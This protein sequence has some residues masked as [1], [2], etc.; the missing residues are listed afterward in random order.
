MDS[1]TI[2]PSHNTPDKKDMF[3]MSLLEYICIKHDPQKTSLFPELVGYLQSN[4]MIKPIDYNSQQYTAIKNS[5]L[6]MLHKFIKN[7][8]IPDSSLPIYESRYVNDF[9]EVNKI[10]DGGF[11]SVYKTIHKLDKVAY[12][13]KKIPLDIVENNKEILNES[14]ILAHLNHNNIIRYYSTW[15]EQI[16]TNLTL[17]SNFDNNCSI[18]YDD[19][20]SIYYDNSPSSNNELMLYPNDNSS[21]SYDNSF[22]SNDNKIIGH[23]NPLS[24][25]LFIQMELCVM[26]L[27]DYIFQPFNEVERHYMTESIIN[28]II[29][30]HSQEYI[31]CDLSLNNILLNKDKQIKLCDFGLTSYVGNNGYIIKNKHYGNPLY[32]AP[33]SLSFNKYSYKSDIYSLGIIFFELQSKFTTEME[34]IS[35]IKAFRNKKVKCKYDAYLYSLT[36]NDENK[37][38]FIYD[39]KK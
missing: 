17:T 39:L 11:G 29:Y 32:L 19:S 6:N 22:N 38:P 4:D 16:P 28:A 35:Q 21:F 2:I 3:I 26:T 30:I 34:R 36:D 15:L 37:R 7:Y 20:S 33:E 13:I 10:S 31:H 25:Y 8:G 5:N 27:K 14:M 9:I 23:H 24:T 12:A 18:S 1:T